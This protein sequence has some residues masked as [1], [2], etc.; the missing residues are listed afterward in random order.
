MCIWKNVE[1]PIDLNES[2]YLLLLFYKFI[3]LLYTTLI[4]C[5]IYL[6]KKNKGKKIEGKKGEVKKNV[7]TIKMIVSH[8]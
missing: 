7:S 1:N 3:Y 4:G 5:W 2:I 6:M 8:D